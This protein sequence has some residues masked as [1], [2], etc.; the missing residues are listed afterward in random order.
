MV[1]HN[2]S[3]DAR[4]EMAKAISTRFLPETLPLR[5]V[6]ANAMPHTTNSETMSVTHTC[7]SGRRSL[8]IANAPSS[9][10]H[11]KTTAPI[12]HF[13]LGR[14][15]VCDNGLPES[16]FGDDVMGYNGALRNNLFGQFSVQPTVGCASARRPRRSFDDHRTVHAISDDPGLVLAV[17]IWQPES[18]GMRDVIVGDDVKPRT[19]VQC[20]DERGVHFSDRGAEC[21]PRHRHTVHGGSRGAH[22]VFRGCD[23]I[24]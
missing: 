2:S 3:T 12:A 23:E 11:A 4:Q 17:V 15:I 7:Q 20:L 1:A 22:I 14:I 18:H 9:A 10:P 5:P 13:D 24:S 8:N 6:T 16:A 19:E 21:L